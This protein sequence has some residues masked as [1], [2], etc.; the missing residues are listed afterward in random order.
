MSSRLSVSV[1]LALALAACGPSPSGSYNWDRAI[2]ANPNAL[3]TPPTNSIDLIKNIHFAAANRILFDDDL[4]TD[5]EK[6]WKLFGGRN[7]YKNLPYDRT[8][9]PPRQA[10]RSKFTFRIVTVTFFPLYI[11]NPQNYHTP[12]ADRLK[13]TI[14]QGHSTATAVSSPFGTRKQV[15]IYVHN[16]T[17][18]RLTFADITK[19]FG[20][21]WQMFRKDSRFPVGPLPPYH[22]KPDTAKPKLHRKIGPYETERTLLLPP[23]ETGAISAHFDEDGYLKGFEL[24]LGIDTP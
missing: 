24:L 15:N 9:A 22:D 11:D 17:G 6:L 7:F 12:Q 14:M 18:L 23:P 8:L 21:D 5:D 10:Q 20:S 4:S 19:V 16:A 3:T 13:V 2:K 1:L